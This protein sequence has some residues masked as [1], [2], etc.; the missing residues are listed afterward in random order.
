MIE[1]KYFELAKESFPFPE[2]RDRLVKEINGSLLPFGSFGYMGGYGFVRRELCLAIEADYSLIAE[3][4]YWI[5]IAQTLEEDMLMVD[6]DTGKPLFESVNDAI[7]SMKLW[8]DPYGCV[9]EGEKL[10]AVSALQR[11]AESN[12]ISLDRVLEYVVAA[13]HADD[14]YWALYTPKELVEDFVI[15]LEVSGREG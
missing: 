10:D 13:E 15:W 5:L 3:V 1:Q 4:K 2:D 12:E 9:I 7:T 14:N 11:H 6:E 8:Y